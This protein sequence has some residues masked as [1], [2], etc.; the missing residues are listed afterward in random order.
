MT[1]ID[2]LFSAEKESIDIKSINVLARLCRFNPQQPEL[3]FSGMILSEDL[4]TDQGVTLYTSGTSM[5]PDRIQRL[6]NLQENNP[7]H[8][9]HFK[10]RR[11]AELLNNF[12]N[13]IVKKL[14]KLTEFRKNYKIYSTFLGA[15]EQELH[16]LVNELLS[17]ENIIL[18]IYK[19]KFITDTIPSKNAVLMFNHTVSVALFSFAIS[20][21]EHIKSLVGF[22]K[23][24]ISELVLA[25]F[26]HNIGAVV[27][28]ESII[29]TK[30]K[31]REN[32]YNEA[33]RQ[34][35]YMLDNVKIS[36]E[37]KNAIRYVTD[38]F[39]GQKDFILREDK[40]EYW[41]ANI[42]LVANLYLQVESGLFGIKKK[43]THIVDDLNV[44]AM[45]NQLNKNVVQALT[46]GMKLNEIFDFY[47]EME[48]LKA[49]CSFS[50][51]NH[52]S[53]Y[54]MTGFKSPTIFICKDSVEECEH[55]EISL[56]AVSLLKPMG[57]LK[58]GKYSRCML[59]TPKLIQFYKKHYEEI[60]ED[61]KTVKKK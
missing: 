13:D 34:S 47:M 26:F 42:I 2:E 23:E 16:S 61:Y 52:A 56:K 35:I 8:Q 4:S 19:M 45:S 49:M 14:T 5:T 44:M 1:Q 30:E 6:L 18:A 36:A 60:K 28:V 50:G 39:F 58:E 10:I 11:S 24:E 20:Q 22:S 38:F 21:S 41:M 9:M 40:K 32:Q 15:I 3:F 12:K 51:G 53:P 46:I 57:D 48:D 54:P 7:H 25:A 29:K 27:N 17:D 43:P 33:N 37:A 55:Y 59:T 31:K